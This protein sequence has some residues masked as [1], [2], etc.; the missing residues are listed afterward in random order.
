M[1]FKS[2]STLWNLILTGLVLVSISFAQPDTYRHAYDTGY[3]AGVTAGQD[4]KAN[5]K[6]FDFANKETYHDGLQGFQEG[7]HDRD[8]YAVAFRRGFEDGYEEGYGLVSRKPDNPLSVPSSASPDRQAGF[9]GQPT[10][11]NVIPSGTLLQARLLET[12]STKR[13][14]KGDDFLAEL[15]EPL[16]LSPDLTIPRG[17]RVHGIITYLKRA[18]RIKG[19][20]EMNLRFDELEFPGGTTVPIEAT[21]LS[22]EDRADETVK[23]EEGTI[24]GRGTKGKDAAKIGAASGLGA[25]LGVLTGGGKGAKTGAAAGAVGGLAGVLFTRG[26]DIVLFSETELTI[27]LD[28]EA[29]FHSGLL[30]SRP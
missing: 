6:P 20:A 16:E 23:D 7:V 4:D 2:T 1:K 13:N 21:V 15:T 30:R 29:A 25:L 3:S 17:T 18:G 22:I 26:E 8:V 28:K 27:R 14:E 5:R 9:L 19:R 24:Q 11:R 10:N 12:L